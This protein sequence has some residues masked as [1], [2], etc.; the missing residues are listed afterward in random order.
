MPTFVAPDGTELCYHLVG[1]GPP[2]ICIPGG[3]QDTVYLGDLGGLSAH[4]QLVLFEL[5]GT[6]RSAVPADPASY[7]CDRLVGD[8]EALRQHLG[9]EQL[10]LLAHS[11]GTNLAQRYL[12]KHSARV[13]KLALITPSALATGIEVPGDA[14]AAIAELRQDEP[15]YPEASAALN[16]MMAGN[17]TADAMKSIA[18][19]FYGRWDAA[20]E[21]HHAGEADHRN[22]DAFAVFVSDGAFDPPTTRA[23][24]AAFPHPVLLLAG[25]YDLNSPPSAVAALADVFPNPQYAVQPKTGHYPWLDDPTQF[26][27]KV[28]TFLAGH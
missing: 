4:R 15:W 25:E 23:A 1:E 21:A 3:M 9:L 8:V 16:A 7:R 5:R 20:A 18:P 10:D 6:G 22:T 24:L 12:E 28:S 17:A 11:G 13:A 14:R 2:L 27:K 26:V 19:F